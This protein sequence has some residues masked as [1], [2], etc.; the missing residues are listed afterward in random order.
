[1]QILLRNETTIN[2]HVTGFVEAY[3]KHWNIVL[4]NVV[5]V[6]KR[7]KPHFCTTSMSSNMHDDAYDGNSIDE[8]LRRLQRLGINVPAINV[9]SINRKFAECTRNIPQLLVRGEQIAVVHLDVPHDHSN[10]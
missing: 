7:K 5:H 8:C 10:K 6:W 3:D 2:G 9:K 4:S 1:M